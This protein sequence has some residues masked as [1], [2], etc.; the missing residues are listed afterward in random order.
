MIR[1]TLR[2]ARKPRTCACGERV[3]PGDPYWECVASPDHGD[4]GNTSWWRLAEC[5]KCADRKVDA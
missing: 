5:T 1:R 3:Y 4:L 2:T